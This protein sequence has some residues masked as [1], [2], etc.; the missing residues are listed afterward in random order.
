[1]KKKLGYF[2]A[3][4]QI[5]A[6]RTPMLTPD[7]INYLATRGNWII[8]AELR[9]API[10]R[11][12]GQG[13]CSIYSG[14]GVSDLDT[15]QNLMNMFPW[16]RFSVDVGGPDTY[17][18]YVFIGTNDIN[19]W[20]QAYIEAWGTVNRPRYWSQDVQSIPINAPPGTNW[21]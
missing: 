9:Q 21:P 7:Q 8:N 3:L 19:A 20:R 6:L 17:D 15:V 10:D 12:F 18:T 11:E 4:W 14:Q 1:M 16:G 2:H 5:N 13:D